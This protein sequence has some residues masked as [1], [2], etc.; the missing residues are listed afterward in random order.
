MKHTPG[1]WEADGGD[2]FSKEGRKYIALTILDVPKKERMANARLIAAAPELL[3]AAKDALEL[4]TG[5]TIPE[6]KKLQKAIAK[7]EDE[8]ENNA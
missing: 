4:L 1:P 6:V 7:A 8:G 5:L 3:E 2:V